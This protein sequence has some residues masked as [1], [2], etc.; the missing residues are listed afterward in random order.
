MYTFQWS[1]SGNVQ[2]DRVKL[3]VDN[4][5]IISH[6]SSLEAAHPQGTLSM[7]AFAY[8]DLWLKFKVEGAGVGE[9]YVGLKWKSGASGME[10]VPSTNLFEG[11]PL[12]NS[13]YRALVHPAVTCASRSI[14]T[15]NSPAPGHSLELATAG[16]QAEFSIT[17]KDLYGNLKTE[18]NERFLV[19]FTGTETASGVV[20]DRQDGTYRVLYTLSK[21]GTY[22]A[23]VVFG[24]TGT[25]SQKFSI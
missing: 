24:A 2:G 15:A 7:R 19:R 25:H 23:S 1:R 6:W 8:Y 21:S 9:H 12:H 20:Q 16:V 3:W 22:A 13:P 17:A 5:E 4:S 10:S 18:G 11:Y 14:A